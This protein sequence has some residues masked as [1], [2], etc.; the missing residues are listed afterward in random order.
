MGRGRWLEALGPRVPRYFDRAAWGGE[1]NVASCSP[2]THP[3]LP[4]AVVRRQA[5]GIQGSMISMKSAAAS[6]SGVST[7]GGAQTVCGA[8]RPSK[9]ALRRPRFGADTPQRPQPHFK[10]RQHVPTSVS[11]S[12]ASGGPLRRCEAGLARAGQPGGAAGWRCGPAR[13]RCPV[14]VQTARGATDRCRTAMQSPGCGRERLSGEA[15]L[16]LHPGRS[17]PPLSRSAALRV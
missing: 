5:G 1:Q 2:S 3:S 16:S 12:A 14:A 9:P 11:S 4:G 13:A 6:H 8:L 10:R 17:R 15:H 7:R